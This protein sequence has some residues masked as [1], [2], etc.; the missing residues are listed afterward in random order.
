MNNKVF[1]LILDKAIIL[2]RLSSLNA[3]TDTF[4]EESSYFRTIPTEKLYVINFP[5]VMD[6][7]IPI[8]NMRFAITI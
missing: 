3:E 7:R 8:L 1:W 5:K 2:F 6:N 4:L